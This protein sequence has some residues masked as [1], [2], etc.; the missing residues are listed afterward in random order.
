MVL[1]SIHWTHS[2]D[3]FLVTVTSTGLLFFS[4]TSFLLHLSKQP[5]TPPTLIKGPNSRVFFPFLRLEEG[6]PSNGD[7]KSE[8]LSRS[9]PSHSN[10]NNKQ[11]QEVPPHSSP[12][13]FFSLPSKCPP[14]HCGFCERE[15]CCQ[16]CHH[17]RLQQQITFSI[18]THPEKGRGEDS[19]PD[20]RPEPGSPFL[21]QNL[22]CRN[23]RV[24]THAI[25][26]QFLWYLPGPQPRS[27]KRKSTS[28]MN[29]GCCTAVNSIFHWGGS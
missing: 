9:V 1:K 29:K 15:L 8:K 13:V 20:S 2:R 25:G 24:R 18:S 27:R 19:P 14:A 6:T 12:L 10:T 21:I 28:P 16:H 22:A 3:R 4:F 7:R 17:R 26:H 5:T 23:N 11:Q